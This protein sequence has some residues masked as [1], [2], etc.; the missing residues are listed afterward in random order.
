MARTP[1]QESLYYAYSLKGKYGPS[2]AFE[3]L[4]GSEVSV[5]EVAQSVLSKSQLLQWLRD[6]KENKRLLRG[7]YEFAP[8]DESDEWYDEQIELLNG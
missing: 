2:I 3:N 4:D 6:E 8:F 5:W 1:L 7:K